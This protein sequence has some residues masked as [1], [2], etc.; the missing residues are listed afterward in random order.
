M[1]D[2]NIYREELMEI[3]KNPRNRGSISNASVQV[4]EKN[5]MCGDEI[6]LQMLIE[7]GVIK[8]AK[9]DGPACSVSIISS[10]YLL[11]NL[12]GYTLKDA[13][14]F[15]KEELLDLIGI[16][17]STS[18]VK[19]ATLALTALKE[20]IEKYEQTNTKNN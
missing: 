12:I 19:C 6:T 11:D 14:K 16:N 10:T 9:F 4:T 7:D 18:R 13:A 3:Y 1:K 15:S 8:D 17:L 20:A 5:P 2:D